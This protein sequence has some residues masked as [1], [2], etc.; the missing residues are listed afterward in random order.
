LIEIVC[1]ILSVIVILTKGK[2]LIVNYNFYKTEFYIAYIIIWGLLFAIILTYILWICFSKKQIHKIYSN[3]SSGIILSVFLLIPIGIYSVML[4]KK[5]SY[6]DF[7]EIFI[8]FMLSVVFNIIMYSQSPSG[9]T[10]L[11]F[12]K[13]GDIIN[14]YVF[15]TDIYGKVIYKNSRVN[16]SNFFVTDETIDLDDLEKIYKPSAIKIYNTEGNESIKM[17]CMGKDCYFTHR[18][19]PLKNNE[20]TIG[21]IITIVDISELM[22]LLHLLEQ[23][24]EKAKDANM[25]L[26]NYAEV[27]YNVEKEKEINVLLEKILSSREKDMRQLIKNIEELIEHENLQEENEFQEK[28][29]FLINYNQRILEDVRETVSSYK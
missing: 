26:K 10:V 19:D 14:D 6:I 11:T 2:F 5:F 27:V 13:I 4:V 22:E 15:V 7:A 20:V 28:I 23:M 24:K 25:K 9:I 29:D 12:N 17:C 1:S 16:Q 18:S 3:R 21:Y 8:L